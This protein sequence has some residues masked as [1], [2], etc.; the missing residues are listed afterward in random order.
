MTELDEVK[1]QI[2]AFKIIKNK[3]TLDDQIEK[4]EKELD[5]IKEKDFIKYVKMD[6]KE[7]K[8]IR[9]L[10]EALGSS[11]SVRK[12]EF[13]VKKRSK[14]KDN[15]EDWAEIIKEDILFPEKKES[16]Y[17]GDVSHQY[18]EGTGD[19]YRSNDHFDDSIQ[20]YSSSSKYN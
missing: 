1:K 8:D 9:L 19:A 16:A 5:P 17:T 18:K 12:P 13:E 15:K 4:F 10:N 7:E 20:G 3:K 2:D 11:I 14:K 6:E